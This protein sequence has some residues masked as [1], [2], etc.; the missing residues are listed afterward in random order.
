M[1]SSDDSQPINPTIKDT[2]SLIRVDQR[3]RHRIIGLKITAIVAEIWIYTNTNDLSDAND[4]V[5]VEDDYISQR[6]LSPPAINAIGK[7]R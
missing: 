3:I 2:G 4:I 1:L 7:L 6:I 5:R